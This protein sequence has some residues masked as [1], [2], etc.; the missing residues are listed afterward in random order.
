MTQI[1]MDAPSCTL[2]VWGALCLALHFCPLKTN[3]PTESIK[4]DAAFTWW[5]PH[6]KVQ[7]TGLTLLHF[8]YFCFFFNHFPFDCHSTDVIIHMWF[9][10]FFLQQMPFPNTPPPPP[11]LSRFGTGSYVIMCNYG[12]GDELAC[13]STIHTGANCN[14]CI[15]PHTRFYSAAAIYLSTKCEVFKMHLCACHLERSKYGLTV[16]AKLGH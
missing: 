3:L 9:G 4:V 6:G 11:H 16:V 10:I 15:L 8:V 13:T 14:P 12:A 5:D 2:L 7:R 1:N